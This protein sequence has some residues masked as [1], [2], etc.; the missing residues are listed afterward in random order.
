MALLGLAL[1]AVSCRKSQPVQAGALPTVLAGLALRDEQGAPLQSDALAGKTL[2]LNF[3]FTRCPSLCPLQTR[4]LARVQHAIAE[5]LKS[6]VRFLSI[7]VD[8][9]HD[10]PQALQKFAA[11]NGIALSNWSLATSSPEATQRLAL[12]LQAIDSS[13]GSALP[14]A[15]GAAVYLFDAQGR[16]VQRYAGAPLDG[17]RLIRELEQLDRLERQRSQRAAAL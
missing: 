7:S 2:L 10:T 8:P 14:A 15:H 12:A 9:E 3:I 17:P 1:L 5:S 4:Q 6:R 16:L 11:E 13:A